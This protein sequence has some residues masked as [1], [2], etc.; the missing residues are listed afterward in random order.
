[1]DKTEK[2]TDGQTYLTWWDEAKE[3]PCVRRWA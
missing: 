1:M 2:K 3:I